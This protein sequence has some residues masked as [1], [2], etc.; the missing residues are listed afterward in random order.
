[1]F[2]IGFE[3]LLVLIVVGLFVIG[4]ERLPAAARWLVQARRAVRSYTTDARQSLDAEFGPELRQVRDVL[5]DLPLQEFRTL[6]SP[7]QLATQ[8]LLSV[9]AD[10][11]GPAAPAPATRA[12]TGSAPPRRHESLPEGARPPVD[13]E[14]T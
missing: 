2:G 7:R 8:W 3:K 4:P 10:T 12:D 13:P 9:P 5:A 11:P 1:M 14:A 6:R